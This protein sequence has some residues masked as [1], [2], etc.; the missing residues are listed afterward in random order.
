MRPRAHIL[1]DFEA[2]AQAESARIACGTF[3]R[4]YFEE[5][6][7]AALACVQEDLGEGGR[8]ILVML[9]EDRSKILSWL[10]CCFLFEKLW[11]TT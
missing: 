10:R 9:A 5:N 11:E 8:L 1:H 6:Y 4:R 2:M 3:V 7:Q